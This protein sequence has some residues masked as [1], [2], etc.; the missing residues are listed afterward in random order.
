M[1]FLDRL[2]GTKYPEGVTPLPGWQVRDA[3]LALNGPDVPWVVR[4]AAANERADLVAEWRVLE[5]AW[6]GFFQRN[7]LDRTLKT[8]M[9]FVHESH[10]V[11]TV[12]EQRE[13][14]WIGNPPRLAFGGEWSRGQVRAV[15]RHWVVERGP[16]GRR[17]MKETF[18]FD[19]AEMKIP[20]QKTVL[21]AGWIWRGVL[22]KL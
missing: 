3:L 6:R 9:R 22:F 21:D 11:R 4:S 2:N 1:G 13:V 18:R 10:E 15:S 20:L 12:D 19:P 16:D 7:Q 5:P 17:H 14:T 8:R